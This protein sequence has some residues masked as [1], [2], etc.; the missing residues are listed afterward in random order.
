MV[1]C[2]TCQISTIDRHCTNTPRSCYECCTSHADILTCPFHYQQMGNSNAAARLAAGRVHASIAEDAEAGQ[3]FAPPPAPPGGELA[4]PSSALQG[5]PALDPP[6][7]DPDPVIAV[8]APLVI[9]PPSRALGSVAASVV[10]VAASVVEVAASVAEIR[11]ALAALTAMIRSQA[12]PAVAPVPAVR[13]T[14]P[15]RAPSIPLPP[16]QAAVLDRAAAASRGEV[17]QLVNR[18]SAL[19]DDDNS[20]DEAHQVH[21][22]SHTH[23]AQPSPTTLLPAAFV[24][25][26][27]GTAQSAQQ[28][29]AAIV[30]GLSK[31]GSKVKY[32]TIGELD[33]ALDDWA[34]DSLKAG[35]T[36]AQVESIR[37]YQRLVTAGFYTSER[38]PLKEVLDYHRKW[39]KAVHAGT[40]DM[41][42]AGAELNLAILYEVSHPRQYGGA[43]AAAASAVRT[44]KSKDAAPT[45]RA[46]AASG[47]SA[48]AKYP[49][50]SCTKHPASTSHTTAECKKQ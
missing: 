37:A 23:G 31:Q 18:F 1:L 38:R 20:D 45:V 2:A 41:F 40:I 10:D 30:S 3:P 4:A 29:L 5:Q 36:A 35:W 44:G 25:T 27:S 12:A 42:A 14:E 6:A 19:A 34:T 26:P 39:C 15:L 21:Q 8:P 9:A 50:G 7:A 32:A 46:G 47:S 17:A 13:P 24:P 33:E 28:Q 49:A 48:S 11:T 16:H 22:H 43:P